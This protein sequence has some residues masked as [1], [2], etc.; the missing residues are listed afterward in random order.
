MAK[1]KPYKKRLLKKKTRQRLSR[2]L[3]IG[4]ALMTVYAVPYTPT[5]A[6]EPEQ[7]KAGN[8]K[9]IVW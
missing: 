5:Y 3:L 7:V 6:T 1:K 2:G 4:V 8:G 9:V